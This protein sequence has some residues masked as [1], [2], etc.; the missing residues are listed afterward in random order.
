MFM[1]CLTKFFSCLGWVMLGPCSSFS[2]EALYSCYLSLLRVSSSFGQRSGP[3]P[4]K[5]PQILQ[6]QAH[7]WLEKDYS[8]WD[9]GLWER[10]EV[11]VAWRP[12]HG[13][14]V[15]FSSMKS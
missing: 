3:I 15:G 13:S 1:I 9:A 8:R 5:V 7:N 6:S 14:N 10:L 4:K 11:S 12:C 2:L